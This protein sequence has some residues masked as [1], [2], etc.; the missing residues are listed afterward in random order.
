MDL[1]FLSSYCVPVI[2][3][4][5][6][7]LGYG[8]KKIHM[9]PDKWIPAILMAVGLLLNVWIQRGISPEI[10]LAGLLSGLASIGLREVFRQLIE[11]KDSGSRKEDEQDDSGCR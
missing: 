8:M 3:G 5:C 6:L 11:R 2:I 1:T 10:I 7:C 9:I 4:I